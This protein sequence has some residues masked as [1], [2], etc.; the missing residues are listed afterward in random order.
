MLSENKL[1]FIDQENVT[2]TCAVVVEVHKY[3]PS[4]DGRPLSGH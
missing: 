1:T 3:R 4:T 2:S